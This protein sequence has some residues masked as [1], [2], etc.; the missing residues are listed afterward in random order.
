MVICEF[1]HMGTSAPVQAVSGTFRRGLSPLPLYSGPAQHL[2]LS[3]RALKS[4][5]EVINTA[6]NIKSIN[7][8]DCGSIKESDFYFCLI[9]NENE[10][11]KIP[12]LWQ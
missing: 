12:Y 11:N 9:L 6:Q 7:I 2:L 3:Y 5:F 8:A 10:N 1:P 4:N